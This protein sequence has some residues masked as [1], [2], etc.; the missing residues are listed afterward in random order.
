MGLSLIMCARLILTTRL[1]RCKTDETKFVVVKEVKQ[2]QVI[3]LHAPPLSSDICW[4]V[5]PEREVLSLVDFE[6]L[7]VPYLDANS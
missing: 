4:L 7:Y 2:G 5:P 1:Y 3:F 6:D